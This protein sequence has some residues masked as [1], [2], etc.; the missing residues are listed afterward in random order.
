MKSHPTLDNTDLNLMIFTN[1][2]VPFRNLLST[3]TMVIYYT[4]HKNTVMEKLLGI[5]SKTFAMDVDASNGYFTCMNTN[6][7]YSIDSIL[8]AQWTDE[9]YLKLRIQHNG[10]IVKQ[11]LVFESHMDLSCFLME[12]GLQP[13]V[14][15]KN[16]HVRHGSYSDTNYTAPR[17]YRRSIYS[18]ILIFDTHGQVLGHVHCSSMTERFYGFRYEIFG[19][20][21]DIVAAI[22]DKAVRNGCFGWVQ[23]SSFDSVV[24]EIRC[25]KIQG[26]STH[27]WLKAT[28]QSQVFVYD[29]TKIRFHFTSFR[30][31]DPSR[32]TCFTTPPHSC[33]G[34]RVNTE[35]DEL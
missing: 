25:N 15:K 18:T 22:K 14:N 1:C 4:Q 13:A 35:R 16:G 32:R 7:K 29:S 20:N 11:T 2:N 10:T 19:K 12:L 31:L 34:T 8:D 33:N 21:D 9:K 28:W 6:T 5:R 30:H 23:I 24:G 3:T 27:K 17:H 26:Q